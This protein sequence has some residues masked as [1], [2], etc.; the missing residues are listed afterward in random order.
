MDVAKQ[1]VASMTTRWNPEKYHD[2][3]KAALEKWIDNKIH[4]VKPSKKQST[5]KI[6]KSN[7]INF[8]DLLKKSLKETHHKKSAK[9]SHAKR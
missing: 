3:F 1:L 7:V 4:H 5:Q 6:K 2:E 8:V 9:K